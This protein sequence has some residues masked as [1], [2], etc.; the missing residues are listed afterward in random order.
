[1]LMDSGHNVNERLGLE[2]RNLGLER[3]NLGLERRN[4][5]AYPEQP[6]QEIE[7]TQRKTERK[8]AKTGEKTE[9]L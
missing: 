3:R 8:Y 1:M 9:E 7:K 5:I 6:K 4:R 2:R